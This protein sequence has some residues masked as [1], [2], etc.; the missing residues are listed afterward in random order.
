[1]MTSLDIVSLEGITLTRARERLLD[2]VSL[3]IPR[4]SYGLL[5]GA[6]GAG[7][8]TL[9][10]IMLGLER[11]DTGRVVHHWARPSYLRQTTPGEGLRFPGNVREAVRSACAR[12]FHPFARVD[13]DIVERALSLSGLTDLSGRCVSELSGGE[14]Q[15]VKLAMMLASSPDFVVLDEPTT[16]LDRAGTRDLTVMLRALHEAGTT[17]FIVTHEENLFPDADW[18]ATLSGGRVTIVG[19]EGTC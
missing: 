16:G 8:T 18:S 5:L 10:R 15:R 7:K 11:A 14:T 12:G 9:A 4:G 19:G 3:S 17:L 2:E 1:M 6:N 13:E